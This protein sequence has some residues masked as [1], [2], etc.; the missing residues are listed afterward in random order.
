MWRL[1]TYQ[2][3]SQSSSGGLR[4]TT[5]VERQRDGKFREVK[6]Y[7]VCYRVTVAAYVNVCVNCPVRMSKCPKKKVRIG[8]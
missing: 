8:F 3:Q 7:C 2:F 1:M 4:G 6:S 5:R